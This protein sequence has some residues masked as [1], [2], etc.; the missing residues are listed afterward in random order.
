MADFLW[1]SVDGDPNSLPGPGTVKDKEIRSFIQRRAS[2]SHGPRTDHVPGPKQLVESANTHPQSL[3]MSS[4]P[5]TANKVQ[6]KSRRRLQ[7][8]KAPLV[9]PQP[10]MQ[11]RWRVDPGFP[12]KRGDSKPER[13]MNDAVRLLFD[14]SLCLFRFQRS[15]EDGSASGSTKHVAQVSTFLDNEHQQ[16][17]EFDVCIY[18]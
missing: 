1:I 7:R 17:H 14:K 12:L 4:M 15:N 9:L 3:R 8:R 18:L 13:Y 6:T 5:D 2:S 11:N 10:A 16:A